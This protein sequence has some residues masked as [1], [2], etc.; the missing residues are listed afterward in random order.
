V[1]E[2]M[3]EFTIIV[4]FVVG[5][6]KKLLIICIVSSRSEDVFMFIYIILQ[7][8]KELAEYCILFTFEIMGNARDFFTSISFPFSVVGG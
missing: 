7:E 6:K 1:I 4:I 8:L 2:N 5:T 3:V